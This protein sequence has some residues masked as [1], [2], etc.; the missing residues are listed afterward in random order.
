MRG[1]QRRRSGYHLTRDEESG[2]PLPLFAHSHPKRWLVA[3]SSN[4][5]V[6]LEVEAALDS[7]QSPGEEIIILYRWMF[8]TI[9]VLVRPEMSFNWV[10][11]HHHDSKQTST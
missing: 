8:I 10:K 11:G 2:K 7:L 6:R 4:V 1:Q 3:P 5:L 9:H